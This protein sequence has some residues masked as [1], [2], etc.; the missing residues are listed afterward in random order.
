MDLTPASDIN[1]VPV[2]SISGLVGQS[3]TVEQVK[4]ALDAAQID[5]DKFPHTLLCGPAGCGKSQF[6]NVVANEMAQDF[7]EVL[8][9]S[10][11]STGDLSALLLSATDRAIIHIDECHL[12]PKHNQTALYL[13]I[14]KRVIVIGGKGKN[15]Q[16]IPLN[17]FTV[18]LSTTEE[19]L[20]LQPLRDRCK[21]V[22]R[23]EYYSEDEI[24]HLVSMRANML[25]WSVHPDVIPAIAQRAR[26]TPRIGLRL[27]QSCRRVCRS[28]GDS[29]I[30]L[31]HLNKACD[32]EKLDS[33]GLDINQQHY[34]RVL[35]EGDSKL[36]VISSR[37]GL[38][39]KTISD[40]I[41]PY[42]IR[43]GLVAKDEK[44][45]RVLTSE[46]R[47][48]AVDLRRKAAS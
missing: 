43:S 25:A 32:L 17:D 40:V 48:H 2:K 26:Q 36:N 13:A 6:A 19:Y 33:R 5:G 46:G 34:L 21:L 8:G 1:D 9:Q 27:L 42:L 22:L 23:M 24:A 39:S 30:T 38:P 16:S 47:I 28:L 35:L 7:T 41:E 29:E 3:N 31:A 18:L 45:G 14:D 15:L 11:R 44:S 10:V 4:V 37:I 20:V 12:L